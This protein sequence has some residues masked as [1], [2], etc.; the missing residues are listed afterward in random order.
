MQK[1][2][3]VL[4]LERLRTRI[5]VIMI[6]VRV[7]GAWALYCTQRSSHSQFI[8]RVADSF[9]EADAE[10]MNALMEQDGLV[11]LLGRGI[12]TAWLNALA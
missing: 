1:A 10:S 2:L 5:D 8:I 7:Q 4:T 12:M 6:P 3:E 9:R 11:L